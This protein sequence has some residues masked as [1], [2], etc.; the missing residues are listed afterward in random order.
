MGCP[1]RT[2]LGQIEAVVLALDHDMFAVNS[3]ARSA[4]D[5]N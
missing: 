2:E 5:D 3:N 4:K 1:A